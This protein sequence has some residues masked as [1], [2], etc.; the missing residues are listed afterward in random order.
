RKALILFWSVFSI[1]IIGW[2]LL[3][4]GDAFTD[5]RGHFEIWLQEVAIWSTIAVVGIL[6]VIFLT[7]P[8]VKEIFKC[9]SRR[10]EKVVNEI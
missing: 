5:I 7:R 3:N 6:H 8:T 4:I 10:K 9:G 2:I 1:C